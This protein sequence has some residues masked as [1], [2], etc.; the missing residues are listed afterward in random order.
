MKLIIILFINFAFVIGSIGQSIVRGKVTDSNGET[1][2]GATVSL[3]ANKTVAT[4]TDLDGNFSLK[5]KETSPQILVISYISYN[6]IEDT[7]VP[8]RPVIVK[9]YIMEAAV[10]AINEVTVKA[11]VNRGSDNQLQ[12]IKF[13]SSITMDF[14]SSDVIKKTGD[15][16]V[17]AAV[18]RITGV[19]TNSGGLITVRGAGDRYIKTTING[20]RIPTLD[21]FTNNIKLDLFPSSLIN[22]ITINKTASPDLPGDWAGAYLSIDTKEYPDSMSVNV[23]TSFGYNEQTT[24]NNVLSSERSSTDWLGYDNSYRE[25]DHATYVPFIDTYEENF[26]LAFY[27]F[28]ALGLG[29]FL[30]TNGITKNTFWTE[31]FTKL[32]L[33]ELKILSPAQINDTEAYNAA[34]AIYDKNY[35]PKAYAIANEKAIKS[36][37]TFPNNWNSVQRKAP[38]NYSQSFSIG[39]QTQLFGR[40]LGYLFG[41]RYSSAMQF[42]PSSF[43]NKVLGQQ[44]ETGKQEINGKIPIH[45]SINQI[46]SKETNGWSGLIN[47]AYKYSPNHS[48][49]FMF[50]PNIIGTNSIREYYSVPSSFLLFDHSVADSAAELSW[51]R[52]KMI[53][54]D[55]SL[56]GKEVQIFYESRK[57]L[58]YQLKSEHYIP[59][60]KLKIDL[61]ASYTKGNSNAPDFKNVKYASSS[62]PKNTPQFMGTP[63]SGAQGAG[64]IY[65]YLKQDVFD[66]RLTFEMPLG[67][68][69]ELVR[70]IKLGIAYQNENRNRDQYYYRLSSG[71]GDTD[72]SGAENLVMKAHP[73][74]DPYGLERFDI[75]TVIGRVQQYYVKDDNPTAH[76]FG[77]SYVK[78]GFIMVDY[79]IVPIVRFSGGLRIEQSYS[80][81]DCNIFDTYKLKAT[82]ERRRFE[83]GVGI[84]KTFVQQGELDALNYLPSANIIVKLKRDELSPINLRLNYS[85]TISK[86][87]LQELSDVVFYDYELRNYVRGN[88][89]LKIVQIDNYDFRIESYFK[90]GDNIMLSLFYK[91]IKNHIDM[92]NMGSYYGGIIFDNSHDRSWIKG[93]EI[94]GRKLL[95]SSLEFRANVTFVDSRS[96]PSNSTVFEGDVTSSPNINGKTYT[97][98]GQAPYVVNTMLTYTSKK[99]GLTASV[100]YNIQGTRLV[101]IGG[102]TNP[103]DIYE[104]PRH[105]V[106]FKVS[107]SLG[108]HFT[109]SLKINDVLAS[110]KFWKFKDLNTNIVRAYKVGEDFPLIYDSFNWGTN[111]VV[112]LAYK[113]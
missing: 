94:E 11:R 19:S 57:Q 103:F 26:N 29:E 43:G 25:H 47:L 52:D 55:P 27:E 106:D 14:I 71:W 82:D 38:L 59:I 41:F 24:F 44:D 72:P 93:V 108:K 102:E 34:K 28:E 85:K 83:G 70:K 21:P 54:N 10:T 95:T 107:K 100:N 18:A 17:A 66:S 92:I 49:S 76:I 77:E 9:D 88:S 109:A 30:K 111:Y 53:F 39:S 63:T 7:V 36:A 65:R 33:V 99:G 90:N 98:L 60:Y 84:G 87:S 32:S 78:A 67:N 50:M 15:V 58:V 22:N 42:E 56:R 96:T 62:Y 1:L 45:D 104:L 13:K 74:A 81:T 12:A 105:L 73:N 37:K 89:N 4:F 20:S 46:A 61:N 3:K 80:Y 8:N 16:N 86:P 40:P 6:S 97:L 101:I 51:Q 113:F 79:S 31:E 23:E 35:Y 2:I 91:S 68:K 48:I 112:A 75:D 110:V 64:R 5:I 69:P